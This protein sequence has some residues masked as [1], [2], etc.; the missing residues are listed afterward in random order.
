MKP[1]IDVNAGAA[2]LHL[3]KSGIKTSC[4]Y[5]FTFECYDNGNFHKM[6]GH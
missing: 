4:V 5:S 3:Q 1:V 6:I 2:V